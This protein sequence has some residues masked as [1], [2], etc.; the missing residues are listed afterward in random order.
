VGQKASKGLDRDSQ[1]LFEIKGCKKKAKKTGGGRPHWPSRNNSC[2]AKKGPGEKKIRRIRTGSNHPTKR[3]PKKGGRCRNKARLAA[4]KGGWAQTC[5]T[6]GKSAPQR[7]KKRA[8]ATANLQARSQ[9]KGITPKG[10]GGG[11]KM[12]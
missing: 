4:P 9:S 7:T 10:R 5:I 6:A 8:S 2:S 12:K 11:K 1:G 3:Q